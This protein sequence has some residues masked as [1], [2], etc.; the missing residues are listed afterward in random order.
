MEAYATRQ[1]L[2]VIWITHVRDDMGL[3]YG[4]IDGGLVKVN[5]SQKLFL[6]V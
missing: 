3:A 5:R 2:H 6:P 1:R 4:F